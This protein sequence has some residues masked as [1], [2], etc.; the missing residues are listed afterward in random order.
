[1]DWKNYSFVWKGEFV[2]VI[3]NQPWESTAACK[4]MRVFQDKNPITET[5]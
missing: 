4:K 2:I 5:Q 3:A 1:M